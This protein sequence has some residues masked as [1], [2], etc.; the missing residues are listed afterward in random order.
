MLSP[1]LS[2]LLLQFSDASL[3]DEDATDADERHAFLRHVGNPF[4]PVDLAA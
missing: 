1:E 4:H 2:D 3:E